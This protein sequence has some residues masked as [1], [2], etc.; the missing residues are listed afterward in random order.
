[1]LPHELLGCRVRVIAWYDD[2]HLVAAFRTPSEPQGTIT[3]VE[4]HC[5]EPSV[6]VRIDGLDGTFTFKLG[7][8]ELL[9]P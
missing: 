6:S 1:M 4:G 8:V 9:T 3:E 5:G 2:A 7:D